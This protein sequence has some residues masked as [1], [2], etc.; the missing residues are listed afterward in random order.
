MS[1]PP[2]L[3]WTPTLGHAH[4]T[5]MEN[6]DKTLVKT[7]VLNFTASYL[8]DGEKIYCNAVYKKQD[9][10]SDTSLTASANILCTNCGQFEV[11]L[12]QTVQ[13]LS[14]SCV[15]VP[16]SFGIQRKYEKHLQGG[17]R[18]LWVYSDYSDP[19]LTDTNPMT[20]NLTEKDCTTT[21]SNM[22]PGHTNTYYLRLDCNDLKYTFKTA[23]VKIEVKDNFP[24]PTLT[25]ST[26]EVKEGDSVSLTCS[27]PAPCLPH[28]P[29]LTWTHKLGDPQETLQENQDKILV[30]TSVLNF[31]ASPLHDGEKIYCNATYKKQDGKSDTSLTAT[32]T[33]VCTNCG[34]FEISLPQTVQVL[35]GSCVTVP[36]SFGIKKKYE[37]DLHGE[38]RALW[39]YSDSSDPRLTDTNPVTGNLTEKDCTT[40]FSNMRP[41][42]TNTYYLRLDCNDLKYTFR[43][44]S[45]KIEVKDDFS[46][47]TLTPSSLE[48]KDGD[49]VSLTCSAP[50]PCVPHP[51]TLTWTPTLGDPQET[52]KENQDKILVKTSVLN[53]T[54]SYLHDGEKIYCNATYKKQDGNYD[55]SLTATTNILCTNCG[56]FEI[57]LPQTVQVLSGSCVTV[58]CSFG[59]RRKYEKD[60]QGEC[61][62]LWVY[63]DSSHPRLTDTN[64]VTGNLTEKDCTT[65]F[66]NM[67]PGHTNTYYLRLDCNDLKYTFRTASV[68]I[69]VRD[70]LPAPT[71]TP[72]TLEVKDGGSVSLTCSAPAPCLS[73]PPNLIWTPTLRDSKETLLENQDKTIKTS[74]LNF[75]A[76][77][78]NHGHISCNAVYK[79]QD[80]SRDV[81]FSTTANIL[82]P[83]CD[84]FEVSLPQTVQVLSGSCVTIPCSFEIQRKHEK[85]LHGGC[86]PLWVYLENPDPRLT[87]ANPVT[88]NL[89]EKD[90]TTTF[91]NIQSGHTSTYNFRLDCSDL[92]YTFKEA[93]VKIEVKDNFPPPTL[94][95]ST[96]EGKEGDLVNLTCSAPAPCLTHPPTLTWTP[97]LG[98]VFETLQMNPNK[99]L[100]KTSVLSFTA[101]SLHHRQ[102]ISCTA[103]YKRESGNSDASMATS[104]KADILF[105]PRILPSSS[106]TKTASQIN[107]SCE[108]IGNPPILQW[109]LNGQPVNQSMEGFVTIKS[110]NETYL[111]SI[112]SL[113]Q[114]KERNVS[115]LLCFGF[116]S[117]GSDSKLLFVNFLQTSAEHIVPPRILP[118]SNCTKTARQINC[119]CEILGKPT[120]L[121]WL[122]NGQPVNQS[123]EG[124]VISQSRNKTYL[125]STISL[126]QTQERNVSSL[127]CFG[128]NS[129]GSDSKLIFINSPQTSTENLVPPR[130]LPSSRCTTTAGQINCSCEIMGKPPILQWF[131]NGQPVNQSGEGFVTIKSLN[132]T[133][134]RSTISLNQPQER[135]VSLVCF[136]FNSL[137]SD[138]KQLFVNSPQT[139]AEYI[140]PPRILPSSSCTK[141][142]RQI[143]C[144]CEIMGKP[145]I[146]QW[147]F[148]GQPVNQSG[149]GFVISQSLNE[150]YLRSTISLNQP[151]ERNVSLVCF[152]FNSLGS[153]SKQLFVNY[154]QTS[155]EH[156]DKN[157][158]SVFIGTTVILLL[159]VC[160]LLIV[161]RFQKTHHYPEIYTL[162]RKGKKVQNTTEDDNKLNTIELREKKIANSGT[163]ST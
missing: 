18:A 152:S 27:A 12:P 57:S 48:V 82:C 91:Y 80:G 123:G 100:V 9:G 96:L 124:F 33:I 132:E 28:L 93:N 17:C 13:V 67:R 44:A 45:V 98:D 90:C 29:N 146:L 74:V 129:M 52:L 117:L 40:T 163:S 38:C 26:L 147:L 78:Q 110:L 142:A 31:T 102:N 121:Q 137:G 108:I 54:A 158:M 89:T 84:R 66:S 70:N 20:G 119:S 77:R 15:T 58:P 76:S 63:S 72:S 140:V 69:N 36:C 86:R 134:L 135:N 62:A 120:I 1:H 55:T 60:L 25:P 39:V 144:S 94:T 151:Q 148:N 133:Y 71:L 99:T 109:F 7:S 53:F 32:T 83:D 34:Q 156:I 141:T 114:P 161:I 130:I 50:A 19:R 128:F 150:T 24:S 65:I 79:K 157:W 113:N 106:C 103:V 41:G 43:T 145:P 131:L 61:R 75:T 85:H 162:A 73:E 155:A 125:R 122:F 42:H 2:N 88:G 37:K 3:T 143:N 6:Q 159:L 51:P 118:S 107:C 68:N 59:I 8:L 104:L 11:S 5:L 149:E 105:P 127:L 92:K 64:P 101:S 139:S 111:R 56:Q 126:N 14:G 97:I 21:F 47:P 10:K 160:F 138:S 154:P 4:E 46:S 95:P 87:E 112:I 49:S 30:K 115:A 153:D 23:S 81:T 116:N 136:S 22:R 35:S 16:C